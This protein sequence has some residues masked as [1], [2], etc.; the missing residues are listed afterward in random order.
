MLSRIHALVQFD[1][2]YI[3]DAHTDRLYPFDTYALTTTLRASTSANVSVPIQ[4][5]ATI[6]EI[7]SFSVSPSD[8][9]SYTSSDETELA[10]RD[11]ML[12]LTRPGGARAFTMLLFAVAWMLTHIAV[13]NVCTS[14]KHTETKPILKHLVA[15]FAIL[16]GL[17]AVR[18]SMPD[19]PDLDGKPPLYPSR[20]H[21][22]KQSRA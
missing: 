16:I 20:K 1:I 21:L 6:E 8:F 3:L 13:V 10:S 2:D 18:N 4:R 11:I 19:D 5:L 7:A 22:T 14:W 9:P 15:A 12:R 17:P